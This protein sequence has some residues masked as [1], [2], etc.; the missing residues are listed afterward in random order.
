MRTILKTPQVGRLFA[1]SITARLP[2]AML[3]VGLVVHISS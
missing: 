3:S 1:F 2:L